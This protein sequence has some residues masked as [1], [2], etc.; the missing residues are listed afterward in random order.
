MQAH[1]RPMAASVDGHERN[2]SVLIGAA[3]GDSDSQRPDEL[4]SLGVDLDEPEES[5]REA[6]GA[7]ALSAETSTILTVTLA[8]G[9]PT[10]SLSAPIERNQYGSWERTGPVTYTDSWAVPESTELSPDS[11]LVAFF[12]NEHVE[13]MGG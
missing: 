4:D 9:G 3:N 11:P 8:I 6:L 5:A 12:D 10:Q 2:L 7:Y 13:L 1:Q